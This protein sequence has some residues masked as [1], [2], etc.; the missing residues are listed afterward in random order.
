MSAIRLTMDQQLHP[1]SL[2]F[3]LTANYVQLYESR[4]PL[5]G[6]PDV[7][8]NNMVGLVRALERQDQLLRH[9]DP[10]YSP[11]IYIQDAEVYR[12]NP[13]RPR[14]LSPPQLPPVS[15]SVLGRRAERDSPEASEQP[16]KK[17]L[18]GQRSTEGRQTV[19]HDASQRSQ[20]SPD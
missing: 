16:P 19:S 6:L 4:R 5:G 20:S 10:E 2:Y 1:E 18:F 8:P 14:T 7:T 3:M 12:V 17:T 13:R 9:E 11:L 15:T